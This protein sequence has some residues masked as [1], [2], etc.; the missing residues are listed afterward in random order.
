MNSIIYVSQHAKGR[1]RERC[2][3]GKKAALRKAELAV[4]RGKRY[5][6]T[7]GAVRKWAE[8]KLE[9]TE[10]VI[11]F[12]GDDAFIFSPGMILIT[13]LKMP[14]ELTGK[15]NRAQKKCSLRAAAPAY[16]N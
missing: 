8:E 5:T 3:V 6:E 16:V 15:Y 11:Y 10:N 1:V 14:A 13:V 12:H 9:G 4:A 7:R 2:G